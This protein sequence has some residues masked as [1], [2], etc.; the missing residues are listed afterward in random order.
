M[1]SAALNQF[2]HQSHIVGVRHH[3][4]PQEQDD[5]GMAQTAQSPQLVQQRKML[6]L[7]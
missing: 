3:M 1:K 6:F 4:S 7:V 2:E 5:V